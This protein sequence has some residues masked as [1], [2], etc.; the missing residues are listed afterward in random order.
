[1]KPLPPRAA[2]LLAELAGARPRSA[3]ELHRL[4][5]CAFGLHVPRRAVIEGNSA[6]FDYLCAAFFD[7]ADLDSQRGE[8][9]LIV[10]ANRGGGKT[11]LGAVATML[12]LLFKPGIRVCILGGSLEQSSRM[13]EH[14]CELANRPWARKLLARTPTQ[15]E[16]RLINGSV[17]R[18]L[19]QSPRSVRGQH[20]HKLRCDEVDE[21]KDKIWDAVQFIPRSGRCGDRTV[22][23]SIEALSTMH[24]AYGPMSRVIEKAQGKV[25]RWCA[26]DV[27]ERCP[28]QRD[29]ATCV[30]RG[31]C[32]GRAKDADGFVPVDD[33]IA[34]WRRSSDGAW[35][36]EMMCR[37]P[38]TDHSVFPQ[39]D[40]SVG[41]MHVAPVGPGG[42]KR[43]L[44]GAVRAACNR[45]PE[46]RPIRGILAGSGQLEPLPEPLLVGGMD[47]GI[48]NPFVM[49]WAR[50]VPAAG[51]ATV[52]ASDPSECMVEIAEEFVQ[53][54]LTLDQN[55]KLMEERGWPRPAWIGADPA[56][57]QRST[58]TGISDIG[59]LRRRG[60]KIRAARTVIPLGI[61]I[62]RRRLDRG[63]LRIDPGCVKLIRSLATYH[64]DENNP[65]DTTP[66]KDGADHACDAL[67]YLLVNL[68]VGGGKVET[69]GW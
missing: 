1:M 43:E 31:D 52:E 55:V 47:F 49:L 33:V 53:E 4:V 63:T 51:C 62:I 59:Y 61:E 67:R 34:A 15:R 17:A 32:G 64:F 9:D 18:V 57:G 39:F 13:F 19:T 2:R 35:A 24:R 22:R 10:W 6:P 28:P 30:I 29:C 16:L 8:R 7:D 50:V 45:F 37:R 23:G 66:V 46:E 38:R 26:L 44:V 60:Y 65:N 54:G 42:G 58:Q 69:R 48:R 36:A 5:K 27:I 3:D 21:F 25:L 68:E 11:M 14:L 56:G 40:R 12:D 20:V 41:G